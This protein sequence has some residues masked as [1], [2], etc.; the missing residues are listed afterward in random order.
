MPG[1]DAVPAPCAPLDLSG[2]IF[3]IS[4]GQFLV[5]ETGGQVAVNPRRFGLPAQATSSTAA[6]VVAAQAD[7]LVN[8]I[9]QVQT[10]AANQPVR[11][12]ARAM[13]MDVPSPG[14]GQLFAYTFGTNQ[15]LLEITNL[16]NGLANLNLHNATNQ[17]YAIWCTTNLLADWNVATEVWPTN[18]EVMPCTVPTLERQNLFLRAEDWTGVDANGN[19][20][21]DWWEF[22]YFGYVGVDPDSSPDGNGQSL[23][24]DYQN[25]FDPTDYYNGNLPILTVLTG[26]NQIGLPNQFLPVPLTVLVANTNG[27]LLTNAPVT[28]TVAQGG[29]SFASIPN[30][31]TSSSIQLR[32]D[33]NGQV[34][35][36]FESSPVF[37]ST[38]YAIV[39]AQSG[40]NITQTNFTEIA[41]AIPMNAVGGERIMALTASGDVVSRGGNLYGEL[42]DY[43]FLDSSN[44]V[45]VVGLTNIVKIASGLNHAL[46]IDSTGA[47]WAWGDNEFGQL[48]DGG[49]EGDTNV[50]VHVLGMTNSVVAVAGGY[51]HSV[52]FKADGTVWTWGYNESG[53]LGVGNTDNTNIPVQVEGLPTNA[54]AVAAGY[55]HTLALLS[56]GTVWAWGDDFFN[57]L[58]DG[59]GTESDTPVQVPG[60]TGIA[61]ICA[62]GNHNLAL[63]TNGNAW[64]WGS[65][66]LFQPVPNIVF[67]PPGV[68]GKF[69]KA[70]AEDNGDWPAMVAGLTNVVG[71]AAGASHSLLLDNEGRLWAWGSDAYGQFGDGGP[72]NNG[73]QYDAD[74]P[75]Q[76]R[77]NI[78]AIAAGSDASV[79]LDG[80]GNLWQCGDSDGDDTNWQWGDENGFPMMAPQYVDFYS[81]QLPGF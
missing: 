16:A 24:Y 53:Q 18:A 45:H 5:D 29:G 33:T 7:A 39:L 27:A 13:G 26:N 41:G 78:I 46:A 49:M 52:V 81:G 2:A 10:V 4:S 55:N 79:V 59:L 8:L 76:V 25:G 22:K 75:I 36:W 80:N 35:V 58:G 66:I 54:V 69:A 32:T 42:G 11:T 6:A 56:D 1:G 40:T 3:Q 34:A 43:T 15:L 64:A 67:G 44:V 37:S 12:M 20:L 14:D 72:D 60:L 17:V 57:Q 73:G 47:L 65:F 30:E 77:N 62:G 21:P 51:N 61:A 71:L 23:L 50:P 63:D 9:T 38:N 68:A 19:G 31:T 48:G 70:N 28:L 74:L